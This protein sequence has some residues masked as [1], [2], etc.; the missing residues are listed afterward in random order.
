MKRD[1]MVALDVPMATLSIRLFEVEAAGLARKR[2]AL[3]Q[4]CLDLPS[5]QPWIPFTCHMTPDQQPALVAR[6]V[7]IFIICRVGEP[8]EVAA[9]CG[10]TERLS[11]FAH[12]P[13]PGQELGDNSLVRDTAMS[14]DTEVV[15]MSRCDVE[16]LACD[17]VGVAEV[18]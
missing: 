17:A 9:A 13:R 11:L 10:C 3:A 2:S 6:Q 4:H 14:R 15:G 7:L 5:P 16:A 12:L 1:G 8:S 18:E